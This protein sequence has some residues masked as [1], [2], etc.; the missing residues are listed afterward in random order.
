MCYPPEQN[1]ECRN[2]PL[3]P[4]STEDCGHGPE[5][6]AVESQPAQRCASGSP[7]AAEHDHAGVIRVNTSA[8]QKKIFR[9]DWRPI[10]AG[11]EVGVSHE[12][13]EI[14]EMV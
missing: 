2:C 1:P 6:G 13:M 7:P 9:W 14:A 3:A 4:L 11:K 12:L 10:C 5:L 8:F